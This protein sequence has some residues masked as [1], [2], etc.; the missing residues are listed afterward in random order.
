MINVYSKEDYENASKSKNAILKGFFIS[1]GILLVINIM[2]VM[3]RKH[4]AGNILA[5][6]I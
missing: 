1:L 5:T 4:A 6:S 3:K 2:S